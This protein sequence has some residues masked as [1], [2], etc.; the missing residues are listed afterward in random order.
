MPVFPV[1]QSK[2]EE[3]IAQI[4][5]KKLRRHASSRLQLLEALTQASLV[6]NTEKQLLKGLAIKF[7]M[8]R[9]M[10]STITKKNKN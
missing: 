8:F 5:L 7:E 2:E 10:L 1:L 3:K 6:L 9:Y 4:L